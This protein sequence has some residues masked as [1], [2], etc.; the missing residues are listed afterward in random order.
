V[1]SDPDLGMTDTM[2]SQNVDLSSW[3]TLYVYLITISLLVNF[4]SILY[5]IVLLGTWLGCS[6]RKEVP[7]NNTKDKL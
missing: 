1:G 5:I 6:P 3:D 4:N 2:M 7:S